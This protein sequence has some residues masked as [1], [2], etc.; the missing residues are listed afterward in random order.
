MYFS[1]GG[2]YFVDNKFQVFHVEI[3]YNLS[4]EDLSSSLFISPHITC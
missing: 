4:H 3:F 2:A 1:L